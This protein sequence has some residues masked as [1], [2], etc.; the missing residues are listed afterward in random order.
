MTPPHGSSTSDTTPTFGGTAS[1]QLGHSATVTVKIYAGPNASG[2]PAQ[3]LTTTRAAN[4]SYSVDSSPLAVGQFTAQ[5][6]QSDGGANVGYSSANTFTVTAASAALTMTQPANGS[7]VQDTTPMFVGNARSG[8]GDPLAVTVRIYS[9]PNVGGTP[10][11]TAT[12]TRDANGAWAVDSSPALPAGTFTAQATQGTEISAAAT[13]TIVEPPPFPATD[14][15]TL[16]AGDIAGCDTDGDEATALLLDQ[17]PG[18]VVTTLGDHTYENGALTEFQNCY[19]PTWGRAKSRTRPTVGDHEYNTPNASGYYTYFNAQLS[20]FGASATDPQRGYYSYNLGSWHIVTLNSNCSRVGG[21]GAGSGEEQWLRADLAA[22][23]VAC[24]LALIHHPRFSSGGNHGNIDTM[25][26]FWQALYDSGAE[27]VLSGNDHDYER[28]APQTPTGLLDVGR[29]LTQFVVGTGGRS[30]YL[31]AN[32]T[33]KANSEV[34]RDD[35]FGVLKLDL[36]AGSYQWEFVPQA[37]K[38]F[39]DFGSRSCH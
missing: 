25:Q 35:T 31:F 28:F 32:G 30:F 10:T 37:G 27:L 12:A 11:R 34:R 15:E 19:E 23:P 21:C 2:T 36:H 22:H 13:F 39:R 9:G 17:Y 18:A 5:A 14:P 1:T 4:G 3:T 20:P 24:T 33:L 7:S 26:P 16:S 29:G 6:E 8:S 38:T